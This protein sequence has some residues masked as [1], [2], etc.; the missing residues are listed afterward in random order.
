MKYVVWRFSG[1]VAGYWRIVGRMAAFFTHFFAVP[2][3]IR[4]LFWPWKRDFAVSQTQGF[5]P[6]E[7]FNRHI[8][9][10]FSRFLGF[11]IKLFAI[12]VWLIWEIIWWV[13]AVVFFPAWILWPIALIVFVIAGI[14]LF[15]QASI[16]SPKNA[17]FL[18]VVVVFAILLVALEMKT[19]KS[20]RLARL[21]N[22]DYRNP[23]LTDPWF[24]SLCV[25][26]LTEP[27]TLKNS[28]LNESLKDILVSARLSRNEFDKIANWE[29]L[30]QVGW[31]KKQC[32]W[33][34]ENLFKIRPLTEDW[35]FGWTFT[36]NN[37]SRNL[38][39]YSSNGAQADKNGDSLAIINAKE[40]EILKNA[41]AEGD[42]V[43]TVI[44][45]ETGTGR[46]RL[47]KNL[48][49]DISRR[50]V[51]ARLAGKRVV[52]FQLD[53]L[54]ARSGSEEDKIYLLKRALVEA[55][56]AGN[57]I[58]FIPTLG[59]YLEPAPK[60]KQIGGIDIT[61]ILT[62]FLENAGIQIVTVAS[63]QELSA[64]FQSHPNLAKYFKV[65]QLQEPDLEDCL[66]L[67]CEKGNR[68]ENQY[69][70]LITYG[71]VKKALELSNRYLQEIAMPKRALD[72]LEE[73]VSFINDNSPED[74][75]IKEASIETFASQKIGTR[76]GTLEKGE[77]ERLENMEKTMKEKIVGQ[78]EA[79]N[80]VASALR[81][82]RL[83]LSNPERPAGCFL[84]LGPTGVGKTHTAE[85]LADLYYGGENRMARL[86]MSEYQDEDGITKL[87]GDTSSEVE[88]YFRKI[89]SANPFSLILLD[90]LEK[91]SR[92][93]HQLLL[94]IMEEGMAKTGTGKK[95]NFRETIIIATSNAESFLIQELVKKNEDYAVI[96]KTVID[97][98]QR[99]E[100]FSPELLNRFD[101][102][103]VFHPLRRD[104]IVEIAELAMRDLKKR[105]LGKE[106]IINYNDAFVRKLAQAGFD[107]AFGAR[108]L[109]RVVEK[110]IED[111][112]A[113]DLLAGNIAR[114][115]EFVLPI[116]YL[117]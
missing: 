63:Q 39:F 86:D 90:E 71:A 95:L 89:I 35:V 32:W 77:K 69:G 94:Q 20:R 84:F 59:N 43:N 73:A 98:I 96:Q 82:R 92:E 85:V 42:G 91:S 106:I 40:L 34:K 19:I 9:S 62:D 61:P 49:L 5:N 47:V 27:D 31:A 10:L 64:L 18:A 65:I 15:P 11:L 13:S 115:E 72:F 107:P 57:I 110:Q 14:I 109:R 102:I 48:A 111:A 101:E 99:D 113:K 4:T 25:H 103:I 80:A 104:E 24:L 97:E 78:T 21:A 87:L 66:I 22:P 112:I 8:F 108:G 76:V 50:N 81:R 45:G 93:V 41:L 23:C 17:I 79:I 1:G 28:W 3:M 67:L 16:P 30:K 58:L 68:L 83:D 46:K 75:V 29:I 53:N 36:L 51:P 116:N 38:D 26:L 114:G 60:E 100:I 74:H 117:E 12:L 33:S 105:L 37:F 56:A 7:W 6:K 70:K 2:L 52:D 55:C 54:L 88:G 44:A